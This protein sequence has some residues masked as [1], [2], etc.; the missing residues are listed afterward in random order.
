[1]YKLLYFFLLLAAISISCNQNHSNSENHDKD[2]HHHAKPEGHD[3]HRGSDEGALPEGQL[4][5]ENET[6]LK[7]I[8]QLTFGGDNAEAYFSFDNKE[9]VFQANNEK[10]G[11]ECDQI[12]Y[13]PVDRGTNGN[14]PPMISTGKGRTTC[15]FFMPGN[16]QVIYAST[17]LGGDACPE[18]P[19]SVNGKYVWAVHQEYDIFIADRDGNILKQLTD[20][21]GYDAEPTV[22]P[23]GTKIVFTSIRS[24]DLELWTMDIDGSNQKTGNKRT[25]I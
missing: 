3:H 5:Y 6:H 18:A 9:L 7:N 12:Y 16:Q 25:G 19:R 15:S 8:R 22:S 11:T 1:M 17:H 2:E 21:P 4:N 24:G 23:D 20:T 10:W 14:K 13:M